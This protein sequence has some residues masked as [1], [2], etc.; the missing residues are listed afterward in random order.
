MKCSSCENELD[1]EEAADPRIDP[2]DG[3]PLCDEC[4]RED[5]ENVCSLCE[6]LYEKQDADS[7]PG[8]LIIVFKDTDGNPSGYYRVRRWPIF[9]GPLLGG[10]MYWDS[11]RYVAPLSTEER[12]PS[13]RESYVA[14]PLCPDCQQK[15]EARIRADSKRR[16][17]LRRRLIKRHKGTT[18]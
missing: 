13:R 17:T 10:G 15:I 9:G 18:T 4:Y 14:G 8:E 16:V 1:S 3:K 2:D 12:R 7:R 5:Y 11:L 6:N